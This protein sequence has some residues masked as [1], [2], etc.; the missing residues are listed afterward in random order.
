MANFTMVPCRVTRNYF[1]QNEIADAHARHTASK[2][3]EAHQV[4]IGHTRASVAEFKPLW[5]VTP[6]QAVALIVVA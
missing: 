1:S 2:Q 5:F 3:G 6:V 4:G